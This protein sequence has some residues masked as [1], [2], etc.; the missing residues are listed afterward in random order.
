MICDDFKTHWTLHET[1]WI[2]YL[3]WDKEC[4]I[5]WSA[6]S[7]CTLYPSLTNQLLNHNLKFHF[8]S[9]GRS[10]QLISYMY[11]WL[12]ANLVWCF[13]TRISS[14]LIPWEFPWSVR[15]TK[16]LIF[17]LFLSSFLWLSRAWASKSTLYN[18]TQQFLWNNHPLIEQQ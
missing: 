3:R 16:S 9:M 4:I 2:N 11:M 5:N 6:W 18:S 15:Y 8:K 13:P 7:S 12:N 14:Y 10:V 1:K 17:L